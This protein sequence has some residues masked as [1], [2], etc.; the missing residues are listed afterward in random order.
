MKKEI[1]HLTQAI[2]GNRGENIL[3]QLFWWDLHNIDDETWQDIKKI[4]RPIFLLNLDTKFLNKILVD[5][6]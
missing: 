1:M 5:Q 4:F 6:I 3:F 2:L